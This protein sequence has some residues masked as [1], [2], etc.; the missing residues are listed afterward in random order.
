[1]SKMRVVSD[2]LMVQCSDVVV[3]DRH[4]KDMGDLQSLADSILEVGLLQPIVITSANRLVCGERRLRA[5][6]D[7]LKE[8]VIKATIV[9]I[10]SIVAGEHHENQMREAFKPSEMVS[11]AAAVKAEAGERRGQPTKGAK[12]IVDKCPQLETGTKTREVAA[13][14]AGFDNYKSLERATKVVE[15]GTPA[16][17]EA[18]DSRKVS[19]SKAAKIAELPKAEQKREL[20]KP[21]AITRR[22]SSSEGE[23]SE[24][25]SP[26]KW[27]ISG[28]T[29]ALRSI[30]AKWATACP[31]K[32]TEELVEILRDLANQVEGGNW[33]EC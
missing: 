22:K 33:N 8:R 32:K 25:E 5:V 19:I 9:D 4:R 26:I 15:R 6:R 30:V 21:R 3:G 27:S 12:S 13:K 14:Q 7:I 20:E 31:D 18:M 2:E 29:V 28:C 17:I 1:M 10:E 16:L 24:T 23:P 11:I